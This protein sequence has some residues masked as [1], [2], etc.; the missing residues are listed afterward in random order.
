[1]IYATGDCHGDFTRLATRKFP[2]QKAMTKED[3]LLI[4]G[5]FGGVWDGSRREEHWLDWLEA[6]PFTTLFIDG[7]HENFDLLERYPVIPWK[8]GLVRQI[9]P[10][11]LQLCRGHVF[12]IDG[13]RIFA[14]GGARS[15]DYKVILEPGPDLNKR[16]RFMDRMHA[17]Y[18]VKSESWWPQEEPNEAEYRQ[19]V[20]ALEKEDWCVDLVF[21]HCAPT[22]IQRRIYPIYL[23]TA[24]TEFLR[25]VREKLVYRQ[26][27]C[28]H[29]HRDWISAED[30]FQVLYEDI[31]PVE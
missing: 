14:M 23:M 1:M 12:L 30:R 3:F 28:G 2:E 25:E 4:A 21:T 17:N 24:Q 27:Y 26:W 19:A 15:H 9:R 6:K 31:I 22:D 7:N 16:R 5:D 8:G 11:V 13:K 29:Y 20:R 10:S 18:R